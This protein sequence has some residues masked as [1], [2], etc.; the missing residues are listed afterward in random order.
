MG[1]W[2]TQ[3]LGALLV[4]L[5]EVASTYAIEDD[6]HK[7][8]QACKEFCNDYGR[9]KDYGT[10]PYEAE[11]ISKYGDFTSKLKHPEQKQVEW[12]NDC[13]IESLCKN[14][15]GKDPTCVRICFPETG[16]VLWKCPSEAQL[17]GPTTPPPPPPPPPAAPTTEKPDNSWEIFKIFLY[18]M[19]GLFGLALCIA[20]CCGI[21]ACIKKKFGVRLCWFHF[22]NPGI[23]P[24]PPE[25]REMSTYPHQ[26]SVRS[27]EMNI[28]NTTQPNHRPKNTT[29][30]S[31][32]AYLRIIPSTIM[33]S[34]WTKIKI[35][36][37]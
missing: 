2:N 16:Y 8:P 22:P 14:Y 6:F 13:K 21:Y 24:P 5:L 20:C 4:I 37:M 15:V 10:G 34:L 26:P 31:E 23:Q 1:Q 25:S 32:S 11:C 12:N 30:Q 17:T 29:F 27:D 7:L 18:V 28:V 35:V 36:C 33:D 19:A 9:R 3:L